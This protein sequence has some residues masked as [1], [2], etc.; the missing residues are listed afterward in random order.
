MKAQAIVPPLDVLIG[1]NGQEKK[2]S[3]N[4]AR[5]HKEPWVQELLLG[6]ETWFNQGIFFSA[7]A[8]F[9]MMPAQDSITI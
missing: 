8:K 9:L 3:I 4:K 7:M 1:D 5:G 6:R 2:P